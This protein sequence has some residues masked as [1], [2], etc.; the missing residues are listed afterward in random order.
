MKLEIEKFI[1]EMGFP[2]AAMSFIEE[3][4]LCYKVGAYRSSYIMSYLFF[5]NVVKYRVLESS[6]TPNGITKRKEFQSK[7]IGKIRCLI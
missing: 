1:S 3:G 2:E 4:I 7:M 6:H 5:F